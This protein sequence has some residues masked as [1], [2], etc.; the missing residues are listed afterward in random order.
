MMDYRKVPVI[1]NNYNRLDYLVQLI[2]WLE[3]AGMRSIYIIDNAS[4]YPPLLEFYKKC[5]YTIFKLNENVGHTA[6]WDSH[7]QL[8]FK[9]QYY[10]YTDPDVVPVEECPQNAIDYFKKVLDRYPEITKVGFGLKI[11]DLPD[12]YK[13]KQEVIEWEAVFWENEIDTG[14]YK[15]R[16]DTTFALYRPNTRYQQWDTTLRTGGIYIA[17]HLPWYENSDQPSPEELHFKNVTTKVSS[18]YKAETGKY[19]G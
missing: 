19:S 2:A 15:A 1:I 8:W 16:I 4:T 9:N 11:D 3:K 10:V 7:I 6:L 13:R 18:W 14:L 5:P 17:R 12:H